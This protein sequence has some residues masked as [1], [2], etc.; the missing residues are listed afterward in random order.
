MILPARLEPNLLLDALDGSN[1]RYEKQ[2]SELA[3][4]YQDIAEFQA[5]LARDSGEPAY[6]V[7][8][9][10]LEVG[11]R[12]LSIG[13][14]TMRPG[15]IGEEYFMTRGHLHSKME[16]EELYFGLKGRGVLLM[17]DLHG[18]SEAVGITPGVAVHVPG[19]WVHRSVNV[20]DENFSTLFCYPSDAGQDYQ[21]IN[22]AGGMKNLVISSPDGEKWAL[23]ENFRHRGYE[24]VK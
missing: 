9:S 8:V 22:R 3:G 13:M 1:S 23:K 17:D 19:G 2:L 7:E 16:A 21:I 6:F 24:L 5:C 18:R 10:T 12:S 4:A 14:S 20:G 15:K 11:P